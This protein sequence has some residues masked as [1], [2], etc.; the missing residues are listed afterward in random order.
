MTEERRGG[1]RE[2]AGRPKGTTKPEGVRK[3]RQLRAYDDEW[4]IIK[5]FSR[6]LKHDPERAVRMVE[7]QNGGL[8][9]SRE[10]EEV[11]KIIWEILERYGAREGTQV[12]IAEKINEKYGTELTEADVGDITRKG[13]YYHT[14]K[15]DDMI[16]VVMRLDETTRGH[17][18]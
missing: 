8:Y 18:S 11:S 17:H 7:Y 2:G 12:Q 15:R 1:A 16:R 4:E 10:P 5:E 9:M 6:I 13:G 14:V 3:Q